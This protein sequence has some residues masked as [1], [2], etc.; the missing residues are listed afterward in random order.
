MATATR[1]LFFGSFR[2][3]LDGASQNSHWQAHGVRRHA[4]PDAVSLSYRMCPFSRVVLGCHAG[5]FLTLPRR[6]YGCPGQVGLGYRTRAA[7]M[8]VGCRAGCLSGSPC[9]VSSPRRSADLDTQ[10]SDRYAYAVSKGYGNGSVQ[11]RSVSER[12]GMR[13]G[14]GATAG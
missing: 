14:C 10:T 3:F 11:C 12:G 8:G 2:S 13:A 4:R 5:G 7:G 6:D 9:F 1:C